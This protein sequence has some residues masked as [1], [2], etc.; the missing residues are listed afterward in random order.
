MPFHRSFVGAAL[1]LLTTIVFA[2]AGT[3][4]SNPFGGGAC[5][6]IGCS[7]GLLVT[8]NTPPPHG[9]IVELDNSNGFPWRVECGIDWN[10]DF[11]IFFADFTPDHVRVRVVT[12]DGEVSESFQPTYQ[13]HQPNGDGCPATCLN[14][15]I[16][17]E[18]P[19]P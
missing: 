13:K 6:E 16:L 14:A 2:A 8:F 4:C 10:C 11:G 3:G 12:P 7:N 18:L 19:T 9:S 17:V 5:T 1:A 15:T